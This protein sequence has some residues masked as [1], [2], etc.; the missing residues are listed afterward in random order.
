MLF[1]RPDAG[2]GDRYQ[3]TRHYF[4]KGGLSFINVLPFNQRS[5]TDKA[6][7]ICDV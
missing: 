3:K 4:S 5:V 6:W 2:T 1:F 7:P